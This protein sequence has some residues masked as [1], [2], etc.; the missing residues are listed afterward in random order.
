MTISSWI[1]TKR[2]QPGLWL[3]QRAN[4]SGVRGKGRTAGTVH[5]EAE[6]RPQTL[7]RESGEFPE[8]RENQSGPKRPGRRVDEAS[9]PT[10][11]LLGAE[12][13]SYVPSF[14]PARYSSCSGVSLSILMLI[15]SSF[16]FATRLSSSSGTR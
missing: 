14:Q 16:S 7:Y 8:R 1:E 9:A 5:P 3:W 4:H 15:D 13:C 12:Y 6:E 11:I 2:P 10:W